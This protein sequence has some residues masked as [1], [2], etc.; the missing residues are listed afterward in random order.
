MLYDSTLVK[1]KS[2]ENQSM[3]SEFRGGIALGR[4][5]IARRRDM[6]FSGGGY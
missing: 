4:R 1:F 2:K 3:E 5:I 6:V